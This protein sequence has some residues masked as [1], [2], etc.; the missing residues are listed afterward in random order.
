MFDFLLVPQD[1]DPIE[2]TANSNDV[3][4]WEVK[5]RHNSLTALRENTRMTDL[6]SIAYIAAKRV[7]VFT[8][9]FH[10]FKSTYTITMKDKVRA[11]DR[12]ELTET[13]ELALLDGGTDPEPIA[14]RVMDLLD[15]LGTREADPTRPAR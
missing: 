5:N 6:R 10:D 4:E 15:S 2:L 11:L 14:N 9:E 3:C 7:G 8:G 13:I 1:G 12:D